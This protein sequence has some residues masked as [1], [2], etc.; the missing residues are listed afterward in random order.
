M[1]VKTYA[2]RYHLINVEMG[3]AQIYADV[4]PG[5]FRWSPDG[6]Y[7]VYLRGYQQL[8]ADKR[9]KLYIADPDGSNERLLIDRPVDDFNWSPDS[10]QVAISS[11]GDIFAL[12]I[13]DSKIERL[14]TNDLAPTN[15]QWSRDGKYI[16]FVYRSNLFLL[17]LRDKSRYEL[18]KMPYG[19]FRYAWSAS[20]GVLIVNG[21]IAVDPENLTGQKLDFPLSLDVYSPSYSYKFELSPTADHILYTA[22]PF[23]VDLAKPDDRVLLAQGAFFRSMP[24]DTIW[25]PDGNQIAYNYLRQLCVSNIDGTDEYCLFDWAK[26]GRILAIAWHTDE[27]LT[28]NRVYLH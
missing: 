9:Q 5:K 23:Y 1:K 11:R 4:Y 24:E 14:M 13:N 20:R 21:V 10:K 6:K 15:L 22:I 16:A 2:Y 12:N 18:M 17:R 7:L 28:A 8:S 3:T 27:R 25:S 26:Y 19:R